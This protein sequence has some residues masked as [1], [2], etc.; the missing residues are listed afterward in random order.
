MTAAAAFGVT[1]SDAWLGGR[2]AWSDDDRR[3]APD[4]GVTFPDDR[5]IDALSVPLL[6][7][8]RTDGTNAPAGELVGE[9]E[10]V[11]GSSVQRNVAMTTIGGG[12]A[13][14][15]PDSPAAAPTSGMSETE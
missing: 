5:V 9:P 7:V 6:E 14:L 15:L 2:C 12:T 13:V 8:R 3:L 1:S 10:D 11:V 4:I